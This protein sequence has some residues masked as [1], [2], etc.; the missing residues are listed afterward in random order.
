MAFC[1][2]LPVGHAR[3]VA[4]EPGPDDGRRSSVMFSTACWRGYQGTWEIRGGRFYLV[5]LRGRYELRGE[6]PVFA[7]WFTGA[8]RIPE[9]KMLQYVHMGFGSVYEREIHV[10]V[11]NGIVLESRSI[12][13]RGQPFDEWELGLRNLPGRENRFRGDDAF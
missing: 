2:P 3:I 1:P 12:D 4:R 7:D 8:L 5:G 6:G 10:R 9:G 11:Q 13:N